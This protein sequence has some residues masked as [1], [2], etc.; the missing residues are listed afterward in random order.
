MSPK[1]ADKNR[2]TENT[3]KAVATLVFWI[4]KIAIANARERAL[5][6][7]LFQASQHAEL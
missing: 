5:S 1:I 2:A 7:Q 4:E 3:N 6:H